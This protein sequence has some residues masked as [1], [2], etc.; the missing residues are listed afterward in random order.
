MNIKQFLKPD[1]RKIVIF[2]IPITLT[3]ISIFF[4][5]K[6]SDVLL[7]FPILLC[8]IIPKCITGGGEL[9][10]VNNVLYLLSF[11]ITYFIWYLLSCFIV[12]IYDKFNSVKVKK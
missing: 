9:P 12:C 6:G 2:V 11:I 7:Y 10:Q 4:N 5:F 8:V 1:W 3:V